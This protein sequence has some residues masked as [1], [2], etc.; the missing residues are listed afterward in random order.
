MRCAV[1]RKIT[2]L[3]RPIL[4]RR[5]HQETIPAEGTGSWNRLE[6]GLLRLT[7]DQVFRSTAVRL[8]QPNAKRR[9]AG[10]C[11]KLF[12]DLWMPTAG[13]QA[14]NVTFVCSHVDN[15]RISLETLEQLVTVAI[16]NF[17]LKYF[18]KLV[19]KNQQEHNLARLSA[20]S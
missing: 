5:R 7:L 11:Q 3:N 20:M 15:V 19:T 12:L 16:Q 8:G 4:T 17:S 10:R 9:I 2:Y 6:A 1:F 14:T 13:C 18:S